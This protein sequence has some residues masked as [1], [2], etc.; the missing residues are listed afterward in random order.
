M[1]APRLGTTVTDRIPLRKWW[2]KAPA[3]FAWGETFVSDSDEL[4]HEYEVK[5]M[6]H[7]M[8]WPEFE[9]LRKS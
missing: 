9:R 8:T 7:N 2:T 4:Q 3:Y 1:I 6:R 5:L